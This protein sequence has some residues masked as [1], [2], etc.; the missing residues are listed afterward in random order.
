MEETLAQKNN[1]DYRIDNRNNMRYNFNRYCFKLAML[2]LAILLLFG[3]LTVGCLSSDSEADKN[4]ENSRLTLTV[5]LSDDRKY[6][7]ISAGSAQVIC[8]VLATLFYDSEKLTFLTFAKGDGMKESANVSCTD[9]GG[10]LRFLV[11]GEE[12]FE[13]DGWCRFFFEIN[14]DY[15]PDTLTEACFL[16]FAVSV[17]SAY[18]LS[19]NGYSEICFEGESVLLELDEKPN[20]DKNEE[21]NTAAIVADWIDFGTIFDGYCVLSLSGFAEKDSF[22]AGAEISV[23]CENITEFYTVTCILPA[24]ADEKQKYSVIIF[25]PMR[26]Q[27]CVGIRQVAYSAREV[28]VSEEKY[29]FLVSG[30]EIEPIGSY[31]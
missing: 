6:A 3:E 5:L 30:S 10:R 16:E 7:E 26:E 18:F 22:A 29:C 4:N 12:N 9:T 27:F 19:D 2:V 20:Q 14:E 23:S 17:E 24:K 31:E 21:T 11:D 13:S 28:T 15:I 25:L 8:G 1:L